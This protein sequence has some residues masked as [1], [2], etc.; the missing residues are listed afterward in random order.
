MIFSSVSF[1]C[2]KRKDEICISPFAVNCKTV[3]MDP[4][5]FHILKV[6]AVTAVEEV[7]V[8]CAKLKYVGNQ[9]H[10]EPFWEN[11]SDNA[12]TKCIMCLLTGLN[13]HILK[14]N[15]L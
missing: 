11:C 3:V 5:L 9:C 15:L 8:R 4:L 7:E 6:F 2:V 14:N 1:N 12:C 13:Y 10:L